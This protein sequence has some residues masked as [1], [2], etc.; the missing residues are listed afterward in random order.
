MLRIHVGVGARGRTFVPSI[1]DPTMDLRGYRSTPVPSARLALEV[2]PIKYAALDG[3][4]E[5]TLTMNSDLDGVQ[6]PSSIMHW[7]ATGALRLPLGTFEIAALGGVG[8]RDFQIQSDAPPTPNGHY[9]FAVAGARIGLKVGKR[10]EIRAGGAYEPVIGGAEDDTMSTL[11]ASKRSAIEVGGGVFVDATSHVYV[12][13]EA[14]YQRFTWTW[15][16]GSATDEYP[17]GT[18]SIGASY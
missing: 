12:A 15:D 13:G 5:R 14:S 7:Q 8:G 16:A 3:E 6:T 18:L 9:L 17:S 10:V 2:A 1:S 4:V 11:G